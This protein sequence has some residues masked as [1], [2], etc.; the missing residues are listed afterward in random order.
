MRAQRPTSTI[1]NAM[2]QCSPNKIRNAMLNIKT[3]RL[4]SARWLKKGNRYES[5][6][7]R[8]IENEGVYSPL[9]PNELAEYIAASSVLH[10]SD[11]WLFFSNAVEDLLNGDVT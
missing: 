10:C 4:P 8:K 2:Q 3:E 11:G 7:I 6:T 9:H 5:D 1:P